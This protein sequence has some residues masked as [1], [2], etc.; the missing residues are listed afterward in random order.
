MFVKLESE[1][2][3]GLGEASPN[4][5][6]NETAEGVSAQL[7]SVAPFFSSLKIRTVTDIGEVWAKLW[8][9]VAPSRAAQCALDIALWDWLAQREG[10]SATQ[11]AWGT[12]ARP[13][14]TFCTIGLSAP[15]E[16]AEKVE[17]LRGFPLIKIKSDQHADLTPV[18]ITRQ[19]SP[20]S[21]VAVDANCGWSSV[22]MGQHDS[23]ARLVAL[24]VELKEI[25]V[26]FIEQ[27]FPPEQDTRLPRLASGPP[28]FADE[29]CVTEDYIDRMAA[30]G[31]SGFNIKLVKCGGITPALRMARH[32]HA[33]G[34]KTM[35][36]C[37]LESSVLIAAGAVVAQQ[38]DYADLDGAWL[39]GD[40]PFQGWTFDRGILSPPLGTGL[41][42]EPATNP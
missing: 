39:L 37:M 28:L 34:L 27:P 13:V 21:R 11:L 12:A 7:A 2:I 23:T 8:P 33:L 38:T 26:E 20:H 18:R 16:L 5:F 31:F 42:V 9:L 15:D 6:Y 22:E 30:A 24:A 3:T 36:G 41:G 25:G 29:S 4:A 1:G 40:D 32:G 19:L 17:E 35:V 10:V 14:S